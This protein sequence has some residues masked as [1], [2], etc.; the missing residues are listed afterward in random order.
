MERKKQ[1]LII[2]YE[3]KRG[4]STGEKDISS[5]LVRLYMNR[6]LIGE[7]DQSELSGVYDLA[8]NTQPNENTPL[9]EFSSIWKQKES[10]LKNGKTI[11][12][13]SVSKIFESEKMAN[14]SRG[15][16][17][18]NSYKVH[19]IVGTSWNINAAGLKRKL[20]QNIVKGMVKQAWQ[21]DQKKEFGERKVSNVVTLLRGS[22]SKLLTTE[23]LKSIQVRS[24]DGEEL[25]NDDLEDFYKYNMT[26]TKQSISEKVKC[27]SFYKQL[28]DNEV[29]KLK[30]FEY[31]IGMTEQDLKTPQSL[32]ALLPLLE[33]T[34]QGY[35][36]L[37]CDCQ[38]FSFSVKFKV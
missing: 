8:S 3:E 4:D 24:K 17:F 6:F 37:Q 30:P 1:N 26:S 31:E 38:R 16:E 19:F 12:L 23:Q 18:V 25:I 20:L 33:K 34:D 32:D 7:E 5:K 11:F 2:F 28:T 36:H 15:P 35:Q 21:T 13:K 22:H 10:N 29:Q 9:V 27:L 14:R